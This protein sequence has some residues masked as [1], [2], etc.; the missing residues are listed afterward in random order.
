MFFASEGYCQGKNTSGRAFIVQSQCS[1][2]NAKQLHRAVRGAEADRASCEEAQ[3]FFSGTFAPALRAF[4][5]PIATACFLLFTV[6][7][8][9]PLFSLP[10]FIARISVATLLPAAGDIFEL[11]S[12]RL[13]IFSLFA[14]SPSKLLRRSDG[15]TKQRGCLNPR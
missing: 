10:R 7:P 5:N 6:L 3:F 11:I 13:S 12:S 2:M 1:R 14:W 15:A 9:R 4:D 8:L